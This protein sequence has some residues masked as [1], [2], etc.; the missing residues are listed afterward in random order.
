MAFRISASLGDEKPFFRITCRAPP[1][2]E[3]VEVLIDDKSIPGSMQA[4][5]YA[6]WPI[7]FRNAIGHRT[8][9]AASRVLVDPGRAFAV[10]S[11]FNR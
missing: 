2:R 9:P 10:A 11:I 8:R 3:H 4:A 6:Q 7:A 1:G 5:F